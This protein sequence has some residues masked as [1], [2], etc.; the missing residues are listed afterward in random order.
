MPYRAYELLR[1]KG[2]PGS[3]YI[4]RSPRPQALTLGTW[5]MPAATLLWGAVFIYW[6]LSYLFIPLF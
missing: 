5:K 4:D 3:N 6:H 1:C 2:N